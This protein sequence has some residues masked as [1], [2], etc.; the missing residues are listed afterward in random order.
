MPFSGRTEVSQSPLVFFLHL[1]QK[2]I[3]W[4]Q[5]VKCLFCHPT[6][7][8]RSL[9]ENDLKQENHPAVTCFLHSQLETWHKGHCSLLCWLSND[10]TQTYRN[11]IHVLKHNILYHS[12]MNINMIWPIKYKMF[13]ALLA[14]LFCS[15]FQQTIK[16]ACIL[17]ILHKHNTHTGTYKQICYSSQY[18]T[19]K[20]VYA[21]VRIIQHTGII[22]FFTLLTSKFTSK[23]PMQNVHKES[24]FTAVR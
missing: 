15:L 22:D 4:K 24:K 6:K 9:K 12:N 2:N 19:Y 14:Q 8:V 5:V 17:H 16:C 23:F 1:F 3:Y 20:H 10:S 7:S 13:C 18:S 11:T 21:Q